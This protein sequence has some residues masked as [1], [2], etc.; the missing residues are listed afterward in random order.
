M[1]KDILYLAKQFLYK[2]VTN[3]FVELVANTELPDTAEYDISSLSYDLGTVVKHIKHAESIT[4][5]IGKVRFN[6]FLAIG[7]ECKDGN[8]EQIVDRFLNDVLVYHFNIKG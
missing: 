7:Y 8:S 5:L 2:S 1:K 4:D 3:Q 6:Y